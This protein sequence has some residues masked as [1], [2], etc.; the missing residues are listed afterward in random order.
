MAAL[1][2]D[3]CSF[4]R[5]EGRVCLALASLRIELHFLP[6]RW[7]TH[8]GQLVSE[9]P[10]FACEEHLD[11]LARVGRIAIENAVGRVRAG[12]KEAND[13]R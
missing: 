10:V 2:G 12:L 9:E 6:G 8:D 1:V 5:A 7:V 13:G 3:V 11:S 4:C